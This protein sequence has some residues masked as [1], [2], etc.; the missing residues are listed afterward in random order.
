MIWKDMPKETIKYIKSLSEY[1]SSAF[2]EITW[3]NNEKPE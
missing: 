3:F 2:N 1:D